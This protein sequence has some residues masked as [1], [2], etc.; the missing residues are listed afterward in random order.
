MFFSRQKRLRECVPSPDVPLGDSSQPVTLPST[1][2][3]LTNVRE[4]FPTV[5]PTLSG[6]QASPQY[7]PALQAARASAIEHETRQ[8]RKHAAI[9]AKGQNIDVIAAAKRCY[10]SGNSGVE[11]LRGY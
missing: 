3:S 7:L 5:S 6:G 10:T 11:E 2:P 9:M 8:V 4:H 1:Q